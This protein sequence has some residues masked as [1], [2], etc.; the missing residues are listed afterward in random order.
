MLDN[1]EPFKDIAGFINKLKIPVNY[2]SKHGK[3]DGKFLENDAKNCI[4]F[5]LEFYKFYTKPTRNNES[6]NIQEFVKSSVSQGGTGEI[7]T[8]NKGEI[9]LWS[10][11]INEIVLN[12]TDYNRS[13]KVLGNK[14]TEK[15]QN[16]DLNQEYEDVEKNVKLEKELKDDS[17]Q[18]RI[19]KALQELEN[20]ADKY[21]TPE[22][23]NT[24]S[25]KFLNILENISDEE[26]KGIHL[27]YSQFKTLEG[28]GIF[29][30]VLN[31]SNTSSAL[32]G[33]TLDDLFALGIAKGKSTFCKIALV[34]LFFGNLTATVL[35]FA[36]A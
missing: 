8:K 1:P 9:N 6:V 11:D 10:L 32:T 36:Q 23:L 14:L 4:H 28:I 27:L 2:L 17:Y 29:K 16:E 20:N 31:S 22:G 33:L 13:I 15:L 18:S 25:P 35:K 34:V 21:L 7:K 12:H 19:V 5:F 30:L 24:Y 26:Y 3:D